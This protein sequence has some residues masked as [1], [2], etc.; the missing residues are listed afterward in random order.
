MPSLSTFFRK[1]AFSF[2]R[3]TKSFFRK[4]SPSRVISRSLKM[5]L[6]MVGSPRNHG[7]SASGRRTT[8]PRARGWWVGLR[9]RTTT[10]TRRPNSQTDPLPARGPHAA[11]SVKGSG[12]EQVPRALL[13]QVR[14]ELATV[15]RAR[16]GEHGEHELVARLHVPH[17]ARTG[18]DGPPGAALRVDLGAARAGGAAGDAVHEVALLV[19]VPSHAAADDG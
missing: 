8:I 6:G 18:V 17:D 19:R 5:S 7:S 1:T 16:L 11:P 12:H 4:Y 15:R 2:S 9:G 13:R 10:R 14:D 3:S